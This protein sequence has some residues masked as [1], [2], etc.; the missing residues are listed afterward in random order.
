[1]D[2][3]KVFR[4]GQLVNMDDATLEAEVANVNDKEFP[5]EKS[6]KLEEE[7][8][9]IQPVNQTGCLNQGVTKLIFYGTKEQIADIM[10]KSLKL[11]QFVKLRKLLR[12]QPLE[13]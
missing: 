5:E 13:N 4:D 2:Y 12:V 3:F 10:T 9:V 11:D 1:M 6:K 7:Q 8:P